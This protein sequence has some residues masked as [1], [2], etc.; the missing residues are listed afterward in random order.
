MSTLVEQLQTLAARETRGSC[1][2]RNGGRTRLN[3][4]VRSYKSPADLT[5]SSNPVLAF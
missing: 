1:F 3:Q 5:T 4:Q 2:M